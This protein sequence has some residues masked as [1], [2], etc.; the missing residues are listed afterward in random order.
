VPEKRSAA[1]LVLLTAG[2]VALLV[3]LTSVVVGPPDA[4]ADEP[5]VEGSAT[6]TS[7]VRTAGTASTGP[8]VPGPTAPTTTPAV[9]PTD[10][11]T[12]P[13]S[14]TPSGTPTD[15]PTATPTEGPTEVADVV[16]RWGVNNE[17]NTAAYL[18]GTFNFFSAG[19]AP[20]NDGQP[21]PR[22]SW[23]P[24]AGDV[25]VEKWHARSRQW[26][27][28]T[29]E[30][31]RTDVSG[32]PLTVG[33]SSGHTLVFG[34][35][36]GTVDRASGDA[37]IA[38]DGDA[39]V[40]YYSGF[41][42]F[43]LSDPRLVVDDGDGVLTAS[44][45]GFASSR[46]QPGSW[47]PVP[48]KRVTVAVL[49]DVDLDDE[50]GFVVEPAYRRVTVTVPDG[51][52]LREGP[53]WGAFPQDFVSYMAGLGTAAF[54]YSSGGAADPNKVPLPLTLSLDAGDPVEPTPTDDPTATP[55]ATPSNDAEDPPAPPSARPPGPGAA[56]P[57]PDAAAVA[58]GPDPLALPGST[59]DDL[60]LAAGAPAVVA[61][62]PAG[63]ASWPWWAGSGLLLLAAAGLLATPRRRT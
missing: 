62:L 4:R 63:S 30:G 2:V 45:E 40:V 9:T 28:A 11:P 44:V 46:D 42:M 3:A 43:Y 21:I 59:A 55:T 26:R 6:P 41:T 19:R 56:M 53:D 49:P 32:A 17:S 34:G 54:W 51:V 48:A 38:W 35:G 27:T 24:R 23:R 58:G 29:W 8:E 52:Q 1:A 18:P 22:S 14:G 25:A 37:D 10:E 36:T 15:D 61:P 60:R 20:G 13:P 39:T 16:L 57:V 7:T 12:E 5:V 47:E 50:R 31:L 33:R